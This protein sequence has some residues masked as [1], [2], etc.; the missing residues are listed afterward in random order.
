M[1]LS[2]WFIGQITVLIIFTLFSYLIMGISQEEMLKFR[3]IYSVFI[4]VCISLMLYFTWK[5]INQKLNEK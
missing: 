5:R 4:V 3:E 2:K 1:K